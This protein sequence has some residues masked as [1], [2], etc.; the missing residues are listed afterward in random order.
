MYGHFDLLREENNIMKI[1]LAILENDEFYLN[2]IT[3]VINTKYTDKLELCSF[4]TE[5]DAYAMLAEQRIDVFLASDMFEIDTQKIPARCGFA[6]LVD[7]VDIQSFRGESALCKFQKVELIYKQILNLFSEKAAMI[8]GNNAADRGKVILFTG[9]SG[10]VGCSSVAA[11]CAVYFARKGKRAIYLNL[12]ILG[13][14]DS[15]FSGEGQGNFSDVIYA[16]KSRKA[17]LQMK[18][19]SLV[20]RDPTGTFFFSAPNTALD[21]MELKA[22]E[23]KQIIAELKSSCGYDYIIL[24]MDIRFGNELMNWFKYCN[25]IVFVSDGAEVTNVKL[26]RMF[27]AMRILEEQ[28]GERWMYDVSI[29]YNR[30]NSRT[31]EKAVGLNIRELGGIKRFE[32]YS[33]AQLITKISELNVFQ[34][35][36]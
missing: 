19:D 28:S 11:S 8:T 26:K 32:D 2:R 15:Y 9:A 6:Y 4:T 30:F 34:N 14:V 12:E 3:T 10:G 31:S 16:V 5:E 23:I 33:V 18:L 29:L 25:D 24:D 27:Q 22:E 36:E 35:L 13:D 7:S 1:R 17:N 21:M 20:K